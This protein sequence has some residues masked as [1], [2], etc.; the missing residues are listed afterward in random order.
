[1]FQIAKEKME[2]RLLKF[3]GSCGTLEFTALNGLLEEPV[4]PLLIIYGLGVG[5]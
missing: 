5:A 4:S 3:A 1:M 2:P